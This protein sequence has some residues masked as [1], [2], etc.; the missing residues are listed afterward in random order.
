MTKPAS[1]RSTGVGLSGTDE[2]AHQ[3]V[4][5]K[6][7]EDTAIESSELLR[8]FIPKIFVAILA[9][10]RMSPS[11]KVQDAA[12]VTVLAELMVKL[13]VGDNNRN[14]YN[15]ELESIREICRELYEEVEKEAS[16]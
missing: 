5:V 3:L 14:E 8:L 6:M 13:Y 4:G 9:I 12:I 1:G 2:S 7:S 10:F 16:K 11:S 15:K